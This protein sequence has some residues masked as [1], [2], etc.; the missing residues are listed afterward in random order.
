MSIR[1]VLVD[2]HS[3]LRDGMR[4]LLAR[5]SDMEVV[6]EAANISS[7]LDLVRRKKPDLVIMDLQLPDG[8]GI[9]AL[10][11]LQAEFP[12]L[13]VLMVSGS[14]PDSSVRE[15][16]DVGAAGFVFKEDASGELVRAIRSVMQGKAYLCPSA[17]TALLSG[18][19]AAKAAAST[20]VPDEELTAREREV[21]KGVAEGLRN[22]EI[23]DQLQVSIKSV[24]T[25][26]ARLMK[27]LQCESAADLVRCAVR[28]GL[29]RL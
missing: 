29:T 13:K 16:L 20:A 23:A 2:D 6:G 1:L 8:S 3:I 27:K 14:R 25:Y 9:D 12:Q 21:L 11:M 7:A 18:L 5:E 24:E 4:F 10:R 28:R 17:A 22:K 26:R 19:G 15:S